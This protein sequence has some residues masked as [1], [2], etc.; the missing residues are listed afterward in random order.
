MPF[1]DFI[2]RYDIVR[3]ILE[4]ST[5][6]TMTIIS[7]PMGAGKS[8]YMYACLEVYPRLLRK[9]IVGVALREHRDT[10]YTTLDRRDKILLKS[11][12]EFC[13]RHRC[14]GDIVYDVAV[15]STCRERNICQYF[16]TIRDI[17]SR[18]SFVVITTH[19]QVSNIYHYAQL[20]VLDEFDFSLKK[21]KLYSR[22]YIEYIRRRF[23]DRAYRNVMNVL[24]RDFIAKKMIVKRGDGYRV[25]DIFFMPKNR[26]YTDQVFY[27]NHVFITATIPTITPEVLDD[28]NVR[29]VL[30]DVGDDFE[31]VDILIKSIYMNIYKLYTFYFYDPVAYDFVGRRIHLS[32]LIKNDMI[33]VY[34]SKV[35]QSFERSLSTGIR[36]TIEFANLAISRGKTVGIVV[37]N[38]RVASI[39][40][41]RLPYP[42]SMVKI[43]WVAGRES[44]GLSIDRDVV[45]AW[46]Q[47][48]KPE[49]IVHDGVTES[50]RPF[51]SYII[52]TAI[53]LLNQYIDILNRYPVEI[54]NIILKLLIHAENIQS[55]FR[56]IR[57]WRRE[58]IVIILD[59]R[60]FEAMKWFESTLEYLYD[61]RDRIY[62]S[63]SLPD[64]YQH[65]REIL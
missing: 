65:V 9:V 41:S 26:D 46:Y 2:H 22:R 35:Y 4:S 1:R 51:D 43:I 64:I 33:F 40:A 37:P 32:N 56:F 60:M 8:S 7:G 34:R 20:I 12:F 63:N 50:G 30:S 16:Q 58:H 54:E 13:H 53:S 28:V 61:N 31:F 38:R 17:R 55:L 48:P 47:Y 29:K 14:K 3:D 45:I 18:D 25:E 44:R 23:G 6:N 36:Y 5:R 15:C 21:F 39:I 42:P 57:S 52:S 62:I 19:D 11:K 24:S 10:I 27:R 49:T 59:W